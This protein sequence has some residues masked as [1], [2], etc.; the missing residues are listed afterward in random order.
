VKIGFVLPRYGVEVHGGAEGA[1]RML[2][3]RLAARPGWSAEV[4]T[5]G[6]INPQTWAD[7]LAPGTFAVNGVTVH[8]F[9]SQP[10]TVERFHQR[11]ID[12][13]ADP[14]AVSDADAREWIDLQ[15]PVCPDVVDAAATSDCA[16]VTFQPYL[17]WPAVYGV[18]R[19]AERAVF[20]PATH[21]EAPIYFPP[22]R[23]VFEAPGGI[24]FWSDEERDVAHRV[25]PAVTTTPQLVLGIGVEPE[26]GDAAR[27]RDA[28]GIGER[29]YLLCLGNVTE[30]KGTTA[31]ARFFDHY[32][33]QHPGPLALVFAGFV[34]DPPPSG[35]R[36]VFMVGPVD[37]HTKWGLLRGATALVSPSA[38]ES[39][40]LV[41]LEAWAAGTP[42]LVNGLCEP[43]R[44]HC[45]RSGGGLWYDG[46]ASFAAVLDRV[47]SDPA[48]AARL[49]AAGQAYVDRS[50][51][52]DVV[53]DR[54]ATFLERVQERSGALTS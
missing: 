2:A 48:L 26:P 42:V 51:R 8:R 17:Y 14:R 41:V 19:L 13:F 39:L 45:L 21:D 32:K 15:G 38:Y 9:V 25:F 3:E 23:E 10:K 28:I 6:A 5:T 50:Y 4:F 47:S 43:T 27:A 31:L 54:Y 37:E 46:Y 53:L 11:S 12:L 49:A 7:E 16:L 44:G 34:A 24:V 22:Y 52:W 29:P 33:E 20:H 36:D 18:P 30:M 35:L 40:S 1:A